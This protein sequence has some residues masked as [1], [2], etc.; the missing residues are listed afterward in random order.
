MIDTTVSLA[1]MANRR[2]SYMKATYSNSC[3][4][5]G[6]R[7]NPLHKARPQSPKQ[8]AYLFFLKHAGYSVAQGETQQQGRSRSARELAKAERDAAALG[9]SFEWEDE[10]SINYEDALGQHDYWCDAEKNGEEHEHE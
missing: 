5:C 8:A 6:I 2:H 10:R 3:A 1:E 7:N 9:Y 4:I